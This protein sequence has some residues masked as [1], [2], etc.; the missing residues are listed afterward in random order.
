MKHYS[1]LPIVGPASVNGVYRIGEDFEQSVS[2]VLTHDA[3]T[4][5]TLQALSRK[6]MQSEG[7]IKDEVDAEDTVSLLLLDENFEGEE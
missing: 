5:I 2:S 4:K 1:G 3:A 6:L 7:L